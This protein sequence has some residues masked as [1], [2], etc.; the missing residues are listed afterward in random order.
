MAVSA[1]DSGVF[2]NLSGT[3]EMRDVFSDKSYVKCLVEVEAALAR[4][5]SKTGVIH[6]GY[7]WRA[8]HECTVLRHSRFR[9]ALA[10]HR[11]RRVPGA[12]AGR[13]ARGRDAPPE[14]A[15]YIHWGATTQDIM[16]NATMI[17]MRRGARHRQAR[18]R[19]PAR[20]PGREEPRYPHGRPHAPAAR[21][22]LP[23]TFGYKCAV[24]LS[25]VLRHAERLRELE[26][27][28]Q[29]GGAA[30]LG[31]HDPAITWHAARDTV[32]KVLGFLALLGEP[33]APGGAGPR[34]PCR[35]SATPIASEVVL[36]AGPAAA[37]LAL[38]AVVVDF[39]RPWHLESVAVPEAFVALRHAN[40]V[41]AGLVVHTGAMLHNLAASRGLIVA[42][43]VMMALARH[44]GRQPA[45]DLVYDACRESIESGGL[46][47]DVLRTR[48]EVVVSIADVELVALCDPRN[49]FGASQLM[50]D[51]VVKVASMSLGRQSQ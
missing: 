5:Q 42:E 49:Y 9:K 38:D 41:L 34:P 35:R 39:E 48:P 43:A 18:A 25:A 44:V 11:P 40:F 4:A 50:V 32:A 28:C 12:A 6:T 7:G 15:K 31:L 45:H 10:G 24:Y 27:R 14:V 30:E 19:R 29:L 46:L 8:A 37:G 33:F 13:A 17:Q 21:P 47:L 22:A 16:D 26:P 2:R 23:C 1:L 20:R 36:A 51:H 3:K